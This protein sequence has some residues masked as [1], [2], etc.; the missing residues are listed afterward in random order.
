[1][2]ENL[3]V[4]AQ[5]FPSMI[6][7]FRGEIERALPKHLNADRMCRIALTEFRKNPKLA[8]CD[9]RSVFAAVIQSSQL[10]LEVG[11]MGEASLVPFKD[12]CQLIP[13]YTG[14]MK[15]ARNSG[16]VKDIYAHEVRENDFFELVFGLDRS[17]KH[18]PL[19]A[20]KGGFPAT[21][22]ERGDIVGYY[23]VGVLTDGSTTFQAMSQ[24]EVSKI[25]D[26][27]ANYKLA[28]QYGKTT[29]WDDHPVEM[30]KKTV[31]RRLC[32]YLPKSPELAEALAMDAVVE[33][34]GRQQITLTDAVNGTW[35][36]SVDD[37]LDVDSVTVIDQEIIVQFDKLVSEY[38][39][40]TDKIGEF[41]RLTADANKA[42]IESLKS[43]A[44][45]NWNEFVKAFE[46]WL[47]KQTN[48]N[49]PAE[50]PPA[51]EA[52]TGTGTS[53]EQVSFS[54]EYKELM[55]VK[56]Q[57]PKYFAEAKKELGISPDTIMNCLNLSAFISQKVDQEAAAAEQVE[58]QV[59]EIPPVT[60]TS[61]F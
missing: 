14:L 4:R 17:L 10:G 1:M 21:E 51:P 19:K 41:I 59:F 20:I 15:L 46:I 18:I 22:E 52:E 54:K 40:D 36:P 5:D 47:S 48:G 34:S 50:S 58:S 45:A 42:T 16:K 2:T 55:S 7:K 61:G 44:V 49:K 26:K 39:V 35:S 25:R 24:Q 6:Q 57:F 60:D 43:R 3:P 33:S 38:G 23:A 28:K 13:G 31:I 30:G 37:F 12:E 53:V 11:L 27:S 8:K 29:I 9:P 56:K 32:K